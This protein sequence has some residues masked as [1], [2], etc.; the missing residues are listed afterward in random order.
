MI[1][2]P[3]KKRLLEVILFEMQRVLANQPYLEK[4]YSA[5]FCL[6][7]YGLL[8]VG[9]IGTGSHPIRAK[10]IHIGQN[11]D[12]IM[13]LLHSSKTHRKESRLQ[14][15]KIEATNKSDKGKNRFFCPFALMP[16]YLKARGCYH[17][18]DE[19]CFNFRDGMPV[20]LNI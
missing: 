6:G 18:N 3:I 19:P 15:I 2:M 5:A 4:L 16:C 9:E 12:K 11:K 10:D 17:R 20:T 8:R 1:R 13:I 14:K 7:Y